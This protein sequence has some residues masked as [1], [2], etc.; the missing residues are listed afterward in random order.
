MGRD[1]RQKRRNRPPAGLRG[2]GKQE[3]KKRAL[4]PRGE[5]ARQG[6]TIFVTA[7]T[8]KHF[9]EDVRLAVTVTSHRGLPSGVAIQGYVAADR[10]LQQADLEPSGYGK[11][12][13]G[14]A[15]L[16]RADVVSGRLRSGEPAG[17]KGE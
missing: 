1:R 6:T 9:Y 12:A 13:T 11:L 15:A 3:R 8:P 7:E 2:P 5:A 16:A 4:P 10:L 17:V 14:V